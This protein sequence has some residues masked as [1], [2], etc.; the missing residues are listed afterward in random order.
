VR[1]DLKTKSSTKNNTKTTT[2]PPTPKKKKKEKKK[3]KE[4]MVLGSAFLC[5]IWSVISFKF[6][7]TFIYSLR[8]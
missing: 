6:R 1:A 4:K 2:P 3:E 7:L 8:E 5:T